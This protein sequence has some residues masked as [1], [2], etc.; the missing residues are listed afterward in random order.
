MSNSNPKSNGK[1][2]VLVG[3][4][5]PAFNLSEVQQ[6]HANLDRC[7]VPRRLK[8]A[9]LSLPERISYLAGMLTTARDAA[10]HKQI[11][12]ISKRE[13]DMHTEYPESEVKS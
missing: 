6:S 11:F 12:V 3:R 5:G 9:A 8:G 4:V 7:G 10:I 2:V 13:F 1:Q